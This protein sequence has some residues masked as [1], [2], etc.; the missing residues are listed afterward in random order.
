MTVGSDLHLFREGIEPKWEDAQCEAGGKW[1]INLPKGSAQVLDANW[2]HA[3]LACIGEQFGDGDEIC[4]IVVNV[5]AKQNRISLWTKTASNEAA[6]VSIG[7]QLRK[8]SD[9]GN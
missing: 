7:K 8:F 9:L 6:Q 5:R 4:G 1:T 3:V 2:L